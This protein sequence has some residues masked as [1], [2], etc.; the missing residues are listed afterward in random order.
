VDIA[1][2]E[3][4]QY[5]PITVSIQASAFH[6]C[7]PR[8]TF[9]DL[10]RYT[11]VELAVWQTSFHMCLPSALGIHNFDHLFEKDTDSPVAGYVPMQTVENFL[12]A[13]HQRAMN[14]LDEN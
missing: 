3:P 11:H 2:L 14:M 7:L 8:E 6:Y 10:S 5:G 12:D 1:Y 13:A 9:D 4:I